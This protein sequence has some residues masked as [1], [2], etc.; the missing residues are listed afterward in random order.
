MSPLELIMI[1]VFRL[2]R[3]TKLIFSVSCLIQDNQST[4]AFKPAVKSSVESATVISR[5]E[6]KLPV[7]DRELSPRRPLARSVVSLL[8]QAAEKKTKDSSNIASSIAG[9]SGSA[10][11]RP[12]MVG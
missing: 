11:G 5:T 3:N 12:I 9:A 2:Y 7:S 10:G 4:I 6:S 8:I 1:D